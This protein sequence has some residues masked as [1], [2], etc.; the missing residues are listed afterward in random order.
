MA[1]IHS[2]T[3]YRFA[4]LALLWL[5]AGSGL[6][7]STGS[8][9]GEPFREIISAGSSHNCVIRL[10]M[11][12]ACWGADGSGQS[13]PPPCCMSLLSSGM[14]TGKYCTPTSPPTLLP[15]GHFS[16]YAKLYR[17]IMPTAFSSIIAIAF[18]PVRWINPFA[19]W[20]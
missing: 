20:A 7:V 9:A 1:Q 13:S 2:I 17:P 8:V 16:S 10:D 19:I 14:R 11:T 4:G 5:F 18:S 3:F 12:V 15:P 6:L